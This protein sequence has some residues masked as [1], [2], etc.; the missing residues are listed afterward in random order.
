MLTF[1]VGFYKTLRGGIPMKRFHIYV[2]LVLSM[3]FLLF[4][5]E[6]SAETLSSQY[7]I[8]DLESWNLYDIETNRYKTP[9]D[10]VNEFDALVESISR[11]L[12]L[13]PPNF[14]FQ[15]SFAVRNGSDFYSPNKIILN[16]ILLKSDHL[17]LA[18][19]LTHGLAQDAYR[20]SL[21]EGLACYMQSIYGR[22]D[23]HTLGFPVHS[24]AKEYFDLCDP[25][26]LKGL[27][28]G[29]INKTALDW[30]EIE[31]FYIYSHSFVKYLIDTYGVDQFMALYRTS[32]ITPYENTVVQ[33]TADEIIEHWLAHIQVEPDLDLHKLAEE[34]YEFAESCLELVGD[35]DFLGLR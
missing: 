5:I 18:H 26:L 31:F 8:L 4:P 10:F 22:I 12:H 11:H 16:E 24:V 23:S 6:V 3:L 28:N 32:T 13:V 15:V 2:G 17:P 1:H 27:V 21:S 33:L 9:E 7:C 19:E 20:D 34:G 30:H 29:S 25:V 35:E 14:K